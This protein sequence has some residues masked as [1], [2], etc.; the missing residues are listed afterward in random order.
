MKKDGRIKLVVGVYWYKPMS[1][2]D[3][4]GWGWMD[5]CVSA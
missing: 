4:M 2:R 5:D 1:I 3:G